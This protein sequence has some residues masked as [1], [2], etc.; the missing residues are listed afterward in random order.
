MLVKIRNEQ[1][2]ITQVFFLYQKWSEQLLNLEELVKLNLKLINLVA[3]F[4]L[5]RTAVLI[6]LMEMDVF[7][8]N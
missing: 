5:I 8:L 3:S 7:L 4:K 1:I 6:Q 2:K